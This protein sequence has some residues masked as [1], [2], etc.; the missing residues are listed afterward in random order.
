MF[1]NGVLNK[2]KKNVNVH[3]RDIMKLNSYNSSRPCSHDNNKYIMKSAVYNLYELENR[4][5]EFRRGDSTAI[6]REAKLFS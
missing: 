3:I 1:R 6:S 4:T 5:F 2:I